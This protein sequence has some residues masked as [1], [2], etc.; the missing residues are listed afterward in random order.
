MNGSGAR[1]DRHGRDG[2]W[3]R[4]SKDIPEGGYYLTF[5]CIM[6][7]FY[8]GTEAMIPRIY[9]LLGTRWGFNPDARSGWTCCTGIA[10]HGDVMPIEGT[11]LTVARLWSIAQASGL[12]VITPVCVTSFGVHL[13]CRDLY[14][15]EPG[16][17][18][19]IDRLLM[20]SCGRT[21]EIP[22]HILH[23]SDVFYRYRDVLRDRHFRYTL[24]ER[25]TGRPLRVVDHVGC[26]YNK[27]FPAEH[28]IGSS[29]GCRVLADPLRSWGAEEVEYPERKG[30]CGMGFRQ[31][32][33]MPNRGATIAR[34][35]KK[36]RS[37]APFEPDLI[38]TNCPGCS[39]FLDK[40][41]WALHQVA[42]ETRFIPVLNYAELAGLLL[43]WDPY[44]TVGIQ[45]HTVPVEPLLEKI[46]IPFD[47]SRTSLVVGPL[48]AGRNTAT[49]PATG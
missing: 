20:D 15:K 18:E 29:G 34:T 13:E 35:H 39:T 6:G 36:I 3:E 16:L 31:C 33:I 47:R 21:F 41:Q 4:H 38:L 12:P 14:A 7:A 2:L 32:M 28:T 24:T 9:D 8:P 42:G 43:G 1:H 11:L 30:C 26:H 17:K 25:K 27:I 19:K 48:R 22:K 45:F 46:G 10:Y 44:A 49:P 5:S 40:G 37:M 23:V